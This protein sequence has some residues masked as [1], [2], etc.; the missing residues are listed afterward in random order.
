MSTA[1]QLRRSR[2]GAS[3]VAVVVALAL[4][5]APTSALSESP[6]PP[7]EVVGPVLVEDMVELIDSL[8]PATAF[9]LSR[10]RFGQVIQGTGVVIRS[11][12]WIATS[13]DMVSWTD[14]YEVQ[15]I[16]DDSLRAFD[17]DLVRTFPDL[18]LALLHISANDLATLPHAAVDDLGPS[19]RVLGVGYPAYNR[20][21]RGLRITRGQ[22]ATPMMA[23]T[24]PRYPV[25]VAEMLYVTGLSG[26]A[27][28]TPT[29]Q[30][31]GMLAGP[32]PDDPSLVRILPA[33]EVLAR[34]EAVAEDY[35]E[36]VTR[37]VW[38]ARMRE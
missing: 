21:E 37:S 22:L 29:G 25:F 7:F 2:D 26:S 30:L 36:P 6:R 31:V 18:N 13:F 11:D 20:L 3:A 33:A 12:G 19:V 24:P 1:R 4:A 38:R 16:V 9:I 15:L 34:V 14:S 10:D 27:V 28:C 5:V 8:T 23:D 35:I 17:A 32:D